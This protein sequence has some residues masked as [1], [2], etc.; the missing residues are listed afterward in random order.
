MPYLLTN[1]DLIAEYNC[2]NEFFG[3]TKDLNFLNHGYH[4]IDPRIENT[5]ILLKTPASLY[6]KT[7]GEIDNSNSKSLLDIGCGRGGGLDIIK[8]YYP[9]MS[10]YGCDLVGSNIANAKN[11][12]N[13]I[14]YKVCDA[15]DLKYECCSLDYVLN[16]ESSHCYPNLSKF[17]SE[18]H[19]VLKP[20]GVF[21]YSDLGID[22]DDLKNRHSQ[23][24]QYF[25]V[26]YFE[27][28][29][30]NVIASC[31]EIVKTIG[32]YNFIGYMQL[33]NIIGKKRDLYSKRENIFFVCRLVRK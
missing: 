20:N 5:N 21:L 30:D 10:L 22:L 1:E 9:N 2:L 14:N 16:V 7:L 8:T 3:V 15:L 11:I 18:V 29:T 12:G 6:L 24:E 26:E 27:D 33:A 23:W 31:D 25:D 17:Y 28:I 4:P 32:N 13:G 19:R